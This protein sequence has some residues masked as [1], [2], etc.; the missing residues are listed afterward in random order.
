MGGDGGLEKRETRN[1]R[2][3]EVGAGAKGERLGGEK[4][5]RFVRASLASSHGKQFLNVT[6]SLAAGIGCTPRTAL[7]KGA[8]AAGRT[9][10]T[11]RNSRDE[12]QEISEPREGK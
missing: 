1:G 3:E 10:R 12:R 4:R 9:K 5:L 7:C 11:V 2:G 8:Y 6:L